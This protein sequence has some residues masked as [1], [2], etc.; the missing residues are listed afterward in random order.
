MRLRS[1]WERCTRR[2]R[3]HVVLP[4]LLHRASGL[5]RAGQ[6]METLVAR[7]AQE[8]KARLRFERA[9]LE[10]LRSQSSSV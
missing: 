10:A 6:L 7:R 1:P 2:S 5:E 9:R 3:V 4:Y 8:E